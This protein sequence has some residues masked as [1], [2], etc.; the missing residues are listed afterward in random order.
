MKSLDDLNDREAVLTATREF[1]RLGR[2]G[3]L[4]QYGFGKVKGYFLQWNQTL[5]NSKAILGV[6]FGYQFPDQ[7]PLKSADFS[8]GKATVA[9]RLESL[10]F[11]VIY[12]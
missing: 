9:A 11:K 10:G 12:R 3:F 6:A 5:Y 4:K 2:D 1:D 8:D 7:G